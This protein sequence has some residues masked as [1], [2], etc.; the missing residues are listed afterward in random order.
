MQNLFFR[1]VVRFFVGALRD[2][3]FC[4]RVSVF[5]AASLQLFFVGPIKESILKSLRSA[6]AVTVVAA[7]L[8]MIGT[9]TAQ[10]PTT[11]VEKDAK[12]VQ[13]Q[14]EADTIIFHDFWVEP[15]TMP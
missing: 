3:R 2:S 15:P 10:E 14:Q 7:C 13:P 8:A 12:V 4:G 5:A 1:E 9:V 6:A 11:E